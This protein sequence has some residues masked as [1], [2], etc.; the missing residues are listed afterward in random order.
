MGADGRAKLLAGAQKL[1]E[2][3]AVTLGAKGR[4]VIIDRGEGQMP[5]ITKDG[6]TVARAITP[7]D[8][9]QA[10][11]SHILLDAANK[12]VFAAGDG[13]TTATILAYDMIASGFSAMQDKNVNATQI[14]TGIE[15]AVRIAVGKIQGLAKPVDSDTVLRQIATIS[16]NNDEA[17]GK[18][19]SDAIIA[20][21]KNGGVTVETS[22]DS[23]TRIRK[24]EGLEFDGGWKS[25]LF[26]TNTVK[27]ECV[28]QNVYILMYDAQITRVQEIISVAEHCVKEKKSLLLIAEDVET[29]A[30]ATLLSNHHSKQLQSCAIAF[31]RIM[32][33][34]FDDIAAVTGAKIVSKE[35]GDKLE[36]L[37][38]QS[39]GY[40]KKVVIGS[41][42]TT[43]YDGS[44]DKEVIQ[45]RIVEV[46]TKLEETPDGYVKENLKTRL[47]KLSNGVAIIEVGGMSQ[48]EI[49]EKKDRID[50][51][52]N[53]TRAAN[54]EGFVA[55]GG[56]TF[57]QCIESV[58]DA[59]YI[60]DERIGGDVVVNALQQPFITILKNGG[61]EP[62]DIVEIKNYKPFLYGQGVN[63]S[64]GK[65]VNM[66]ESGIIDPAKVLRVA[67]ENAG[68]VAGTFITTECVVYNIPDSL[69]G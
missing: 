11:G 66:F 45:S 43:I 52:I 17:I 30:L 23:E 5:H 12:T 59:E 39:L 54:E 55:G 44:G 56:S 63:V 49:N 42:K 4:N 2:A 29:E 34:V 13:T 36:K 27:G 41:G 53:A 24:V 22:R 6:V 33:G 69:L 48:V 65:T 25:P 31:G 7:T 8:A 15:K 68:S 62:I 46:R 14:K 40:A 3:V 37:G 18:I 1:A 60:G 57:L 32:F 61:I 51:A 19:V 38:I 21:G 26:I 16:A 67:L 9:I 50:D 47:A 28:L 35:R 58:R 64:T 10:M 20:V